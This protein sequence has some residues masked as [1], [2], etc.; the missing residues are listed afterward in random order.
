MLRKGLTKLALSD[1]SLEVINTTLTDFYSSFPLL[2]INNRALPTIIKKA[3][4]FLIHEKNWN[5]FP[6]LSNFRDLINSNARFGTS[7]M[8]THSKSYL[9]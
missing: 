4:L 5:S 7:T 3:N 2:G 9:F 1:K 8:V 6:F